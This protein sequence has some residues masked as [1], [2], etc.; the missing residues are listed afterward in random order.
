MFEQYF[1]II[2]FGLLAID[3]WV[4]HILFKT[5]N[6]KYVGPFRVHHVVTVCFQ[7]FILAA[8]IIIA[9]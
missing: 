7:D 3:L 1:G 8:M 5:L 9:C 2:R 4:Q 6:L